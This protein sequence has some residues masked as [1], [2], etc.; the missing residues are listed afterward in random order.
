MKKTLYI[1]AAIAIGISSFIISGSETAQAATFN[2]GPHIIVP[3]VTVTPSTS[4]EWFI[5]SSTPHEWFIAGSETATA[6]KTCSYNWQLEVKIMK[7][8][9]AIMLL[10]IQEAS[11][12]QRIALAEFMGDDTLGLEY[13][14]QLI[15]DAI[16]K[17][18]AELDA[19]R[20]AR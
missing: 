3:N 1:V 8:E 16:D 10:E 7:Q 5:A 13:S 17:A 9:E 15:L 14:L 19:L 20:A 12:R 18:Q 2:P 11:L 6:R 4:H